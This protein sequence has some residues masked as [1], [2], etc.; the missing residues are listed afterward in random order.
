MKKL[1]ICLAMG[2]FVFASCDDDDNNGSTP[3][4]TPEVEETEGMGET[5]PEPTEP[6][7]EPETEETEA[8]TTVVINE[9]SYAGDADWV[10]FYNPTEETIDITNYFVC[11]GPGRYAEVAALNVIEGETILEGGSFVTLDLSNSDTPFELPNENAALSIYSSNADYTSAENMVDFVQYGAGEQ[12][13]EDVAVAAGLW[14]AGDFVPAVASADNAIAYSGTGLGV[15]SWSETT[16]PTPN[17]ENEVT[18]P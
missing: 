9:L 4:P 1:M 15:E 10:E 13:R 3:D 14:T 5:E 2:L 8:R 7:T 12:G 6:E 17:A 16:T 18:A 11:L